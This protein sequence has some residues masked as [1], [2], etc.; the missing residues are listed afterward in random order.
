[1]TMPANVN[2]MHQQYAD[3]LVKI[4]DWPRASGLC[5]SG[6]SIPGFLWRKVTAQ[7][8]LIFDYTKLQ[9]QAYMSCLNGIDAL[10]DVIQPRRDSLLGNEDPVLS[11]QRHVSFRLPPATKRLKSHIQ[12]H[13]TYPAASKSAQIA[14]V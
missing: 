6:V 4:G 12:L 9:M 8:S 3:W 13:T 5:S 10:K 7:P 11:R 2:A 14:H 1:M